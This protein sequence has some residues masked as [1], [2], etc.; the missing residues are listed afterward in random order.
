MM[1]SGVM[2]YP[3]PHP[4]RESESGVSDV[5]IIIAY[6]IYFTDQVRDMQ[7]L[8]ISCINRQYLSYLYQSFLI[9]ITLTYTHHNI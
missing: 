5:N 6:L 3:Q 4:H 9:T 8:L 1:R 7:F 2:A